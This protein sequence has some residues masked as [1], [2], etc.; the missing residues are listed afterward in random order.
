MLTISVIV[1][2]LSSII[3]AICGIGGGIIIKPVLDAVSGYSAATV[4]FLS[5]ITVLCMTAYSIV[6]G[7]WKRDS[8][9]HIKTATLLGTGAAAGGIAGKIIFE[10]I[11]T[12][13]GDGTFLGAVQAIVLCAV[14]SGTLLYS[15]FKSK[16]RTRNI[17]SRAAMLFI[18][19][20]LGMMSSFL[21][22]GGGPVNL[23]VLYFLFSMETKEAA[24]NSLY[25]I[26]ISQTASILY[27]IIGGN[28]PEN[29]SGITLALMAAGGIVGGIIGRLINK[30]ISGIIVDKLFIGLQFVIVFICLYNF[31]KNII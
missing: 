25:I 23:I 22:I 8:Q 11:K 7:I 27:T 16:I 28:I 4:S 10:I 21:G 31:S 9:I 20:I 15:I 12:S 19:V 3:G 13:M 5:G 14:T 18:G 17:N 6:L 30:Q 24:Q 29:M 26:L 2:L 1:S